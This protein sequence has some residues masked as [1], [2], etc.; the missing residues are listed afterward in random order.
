[1][2]RAL[3]YQN[4]ILGRIHW[5]WCVLHVWSG[6][7]ISL[8]VCVYVCVCDCVCVCV[9]LRVTSCHSET[10]CGDLCVFDWSSAVR[11]WCHLFTVRETL[12]T[13]LSAWFLCRLK[14]PPARYHNF[15]FV[16]YYYLMFFFLLPFLPRC[17]SSA[18]TQ[19]LLSSV[20]LNSH[21]FS[22]SPDINVTFELPELFA[23]SRMSMFLSLIPTHLL[24]SIH[25]HAGG[26]KL[27]LCCTGS[28][29]S[30]FLSLGW[31]QFLFRS[32]LFSN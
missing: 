8:C 12:C 30:L 11:Q 6:Q 19:I 25:L 7:H 26:K 16:D 4:I 21:R 2:E 15:L 22:F 13:P 10:T 17:V 31:V 18:W 28:T 3:S 24:P 9:R 32:P 29:R 27:P 23:T 5:R 1:M 20:S 14:E